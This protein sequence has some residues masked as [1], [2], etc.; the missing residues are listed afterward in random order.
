MPSRADADVGFRLLRSSF[1]LCTWTPF[2]LFRSLPAG[3]CAERGILLS[4]CVQYSIG[5]ATHASPACPPVLAFIVELNANRQLSKG[6]PRAEGATAQTP[7]T[8]H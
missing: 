6:R 4:R 8:A 1:V 3:L 2:R 5:C 7:E